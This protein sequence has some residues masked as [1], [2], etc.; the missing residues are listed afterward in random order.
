MIIGLLLIIPMFIYS[1][2]LSNNTNVFASTATDE[3]KKGAKGAQGNQTP[4]KLIGGDSIVRDITNTML[5][6]IGAV[7]VLMLIYGGIKY[8]IS[9]GEEK[10]I[11]TAK[12]TILYSVIGLVVAIAAY[13][14]VNW[15]LNI[16][17]VASEPTTTT[18]VITTNGETNNKTVAEYNPQQEMTAIN[19]EFKA[20]TSGSSIAVYAINNWIKEIFA[21]TKK[22]TPASSISMIEKEDR[23]NGEYTFTPTQQI[24]GTENT[25]LS[26]TTDEGSDTFIPD[27]TDEGSDILLPGPTYSEGPAVDPSVISES[28]SQRVRNNRMVD[29]AEIETGKGYGETYALGDNVGIWHSETDNNRLGEYQHYTGCPNVAWCATFVAFIHHKVTMTPGKPDTTGRSL[30]A[31]GVNS[32][33]ALAG[34]KLKDYKDGKPIPGDILGWYLND[35]SK[36]HTGILIKIL[37][38]GDYYTVEGNGGNFPSKVKYFTKPASYWTSQ[39]NAHYIRP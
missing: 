12:N 22:P 34:N 30:R 18:A 10:A 24:T 20:A 4:D 36:G 9:N 17:I 39:A 6:I 33:F 35:L 28:D 14:I 27:T 13:A 2:S 3:L 37:D 32:M 1:V 38:N 16:F 21:P 29:Y 26:D 15:V 19:N 7:S 23:D 31:C 5:F 25:L 11:G 8:T